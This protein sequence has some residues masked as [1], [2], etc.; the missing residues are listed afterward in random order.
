MKQIDCRGLTYLKTIREMKEY[1]NSIGEGEALI[2]V[3]SNLEKSNVIR[4]A[5]HQGYQV[6]ENYHED[7][8]LIHVEKRG[9]LDIETD[10]EIFS[11]LM[12]SD[13][14]GT[15]NSELG[16]KL[17]KEY[18]EALNECSKLPKEIMFINEAVKLLE[19]DSEVL[20]EIRML[21]RKGVMI[22]INDTSL[23]YYSLE[24]KVTFGEVTNMYHMVATMNKSKNLI[25]L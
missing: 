14:L 16:R 11:I 17:I 3:G 1:F 5:M 15:G 4:F 19:Q 25:K 22:L 10:E 21:Y 24:D 7:E 2:S 8:F 12:M 23:K 18:F 9:C 20:E 13:K 6:E